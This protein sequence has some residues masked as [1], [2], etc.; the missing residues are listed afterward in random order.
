MLHSL[1]RVPLLVLLLFIAVQLIGV[2]SRVNDTANARL[3]ADV[4]LAIE[5]DGCPRCDMMFSKL[6]TTADGKRVQNV[7]IQERGEPKSG[8]TF[9]FQWARGALDRTCELLKSLYGEK[10]CRLEHE[11]PLGFYLDP[12]ELTFTFEPG[13]GDDDAPCSCTNVDM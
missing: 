12:R 9:M 3:L 13:L 11:G 6:E 7:S 10:T 2:V 4:S 8:T 1:S 5:A